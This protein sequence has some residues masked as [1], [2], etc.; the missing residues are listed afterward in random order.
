M[1][2]GIQKICKNLGDDGCYFL[3]LLEACGLQNT[4]VID[5]YCECLECGFIKEDCYVNDPL[6]ILRLFGFPA[7]R[8][9]KS[10]CYIHD[11]AIAMRVIVY[12][13]GRHSHFVLERPDGSIL[14][15]LGESETVRHGR[16]KSYRNFW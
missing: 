7:V 5:A 9:E 11:D 6:A 2:K 4:R 8:V 1:E 16:I 3:C 12:E 14:D 15:T 13:N 10:Y